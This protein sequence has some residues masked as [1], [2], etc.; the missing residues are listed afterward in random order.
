MDLAPGVKVNLKG[1]LLVS[2]NAIVALHDSGLHS[3]V[4]PFAGIDLTF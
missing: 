4:T 2:L 1:K 3:R